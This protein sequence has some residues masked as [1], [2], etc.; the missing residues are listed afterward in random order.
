MADI[1]NLQAESGRNIIGDDSTP[2]LELENSSTGGALKLKADGTVSGSEVLNIA[3]RGVT[4]AAT[5]ALA[6]FSASTASA[7]VFD[8]AGSAVISTASGGATVGIGVRVKY[9]N[10]Y[11]W[12]YGYENIA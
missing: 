7:P 2:T 8:F 11:Y 3:N 5:V 4:Q 1:M 10:K 12:M 6:K 9:G